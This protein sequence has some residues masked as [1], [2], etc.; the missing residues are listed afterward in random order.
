MLKT[1]L[2]LVGYCFII[3]KCQ[4]ISDQEFQS[5]IYVRQSG[6]INYVDTVENSDRVVLFLHGNPTSSY[7]WRNVIPHVSPIARCIAPDLIGMGKSSK[8]EG[9][10]YTFQ[11]QYKFLSRWID[12]MNLPKKV[13]VGAFFSSC[14]INTLMSKFGVS[15]I[16]FMFSQMNSSRVINLVVHDW[17]SGLGFHWA[18]L[19]RNRVASIT[20]MEGIVGPFESWEAGPP[21]LQT[22]RFYRSYEG[23]ESVLQNNSFVDLM[24]GAIIRQLTDEEWEVYRE[25]YLEPGESRRPTLTWPREIPI[26]S[27]GPADVVKFA[28]DWNGFLSRSYNIPK[29]F[30]DAVPGVLSPYMRKIVKDWPNQSTVRVR[31]LHFIQEDSPDNIGIAIRHFLRNNVIDSEI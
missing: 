29:L 9:S 21:G 19:N 16:Q 18:N 20:Y 4:S 27:E 1:F 26:A 15:I 13:A 11:V 17:G 14:S 3:A 8:I 22:L 7:L 12:S 30:I 28:T 24:S 23:E 5:Q 2:L 6:V 10:L 31:G 25:P